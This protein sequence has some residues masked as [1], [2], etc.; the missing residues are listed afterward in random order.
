MIF[1][2]PF[3]FTILGPYSDCECEIP[4]RSANTET[5]ICVVCSGETSTIIPPHA[6]YTDAQGTA[7]TQLNTVVLGGPN[8][9]NN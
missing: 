8:G 1:S 2:L 5:V 7:V 3:T 6:V 4:P 9:L